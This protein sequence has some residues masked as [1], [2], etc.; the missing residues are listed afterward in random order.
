MEQQPGVIRILSVD[1]RLLLREG[2]AS[3]LD[4]HEDMVLV[5]QASSGREGIESFRRLRPDVTL[6][7]LRMPDMSG[8]QA[9]AT[10]RAEFPT[11]AL[12]Y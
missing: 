12:S 11:L 9:L 3:V 4:G 2:I 10:I 1:D 8:I 7:D 6:M 5:G